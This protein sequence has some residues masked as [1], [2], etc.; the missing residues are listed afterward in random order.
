MTHKEIFEPTRFP[1]VR[2]ALAVLFLPY[3]A[4]LMLGAISTTLIRLLIERKNL[5]QWTTAANAARSL[6]LNARFETWGEMAG[7]LI[8][9]VILGISVTIFNPS[10]LWVALPLLVAWLIAPQI[11]TVIS[12]PITHIPSPL[13]RGP[14]QAGPPPGAAYLGIF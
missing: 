10:A 9:T 2:W 12:K 4:L 3:E 6:G 11:A 14:A 8:V 13:P 5:L 7:S 1:F